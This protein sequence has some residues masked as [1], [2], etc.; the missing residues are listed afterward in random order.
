VVQ[1]YA[2]SRKSFGCCPLPK[3]HVFSAPS[4]RQRQLGARTGEPDFG[5]RLAEKVSEKE[6]S[7]EEEISI[8]KI[9][10]GTL[11]PL[12]ISEKTNIPHE[13]VAEILKKLKKIDIIKSPLAEIAN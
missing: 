13:K 3:S 9:C 5:N 7:S 2:G 1:R 8:A 10:R 11:S 6:E 4:G 12:Q